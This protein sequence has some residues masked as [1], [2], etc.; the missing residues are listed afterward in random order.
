MGYVK[1][2]PVGYCTDYSIAVDVSVGDSIH[3]PRSIAYRNAECERI[4][5]CICSR[6]SKQRSVAQVSCGVPFYIEEQHIAALIRLV[7]VDDHIS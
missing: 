2:L 1:I 7:S 4:R 6:K 3:T 5:V